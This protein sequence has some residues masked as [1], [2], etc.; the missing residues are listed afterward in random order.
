MDQK[1]RDA[2]RTCLKAILR[3]LDLADG[4]LDSLCEKSVF[5]AQFAS[6]LRRSEETHEEKVSFGKM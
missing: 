6:S 4:V 5:T 1:E 3:D 2:L